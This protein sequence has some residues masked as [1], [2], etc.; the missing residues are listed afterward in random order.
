MYTRGDQRGEGSA[1]RCDQVL[2]G[3]YGQIL[4]EETVSA[5]ER[6]YQK[7]NSNHQHCDA[8]EGYFVSETRQHGLSILR[9]YRIRSQILNLPTE[10][11]VSKLIIK[12]MKHKTKNKKG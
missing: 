6:E 7:G 9:F 2:S 4:C 12:E 1:E 8:R 3:N 11:T 10:E 5:Y